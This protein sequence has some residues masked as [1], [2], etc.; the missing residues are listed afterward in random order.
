MRNVYIGLLV[1]LIA[2]ASGCTAQEAIYED[3]TKERFAEL[4]KTGDGLLIDL[5]TP[6]EYEEGHIEG[7]VNIDF[8]A[9][10]FEDKIAKLDKNKTVYIYCAGGGRSGETLKLMKKTGFKTVYNLPIGY[11]GWSSD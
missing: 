1:V 2:F 8:F 5:R 7:S 6:N 10:N 3:V 11:D 9:D 4:L